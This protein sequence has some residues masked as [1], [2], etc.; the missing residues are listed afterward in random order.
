M[1]YSCCQMRQLRR[2]IL[3]VRYPMDH[4]TQKVPLLTIVRGCLFSLA[5]Q[6][7]NKMS[8][9]GQHPLHHSFGKVLSN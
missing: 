8:G 4:T 9:R 3:A 1:T 2:I 5:S 6:Q 7:P